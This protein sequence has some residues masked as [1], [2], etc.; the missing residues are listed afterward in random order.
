VRHQDAY[1]QYGGGGA[2]K[3]MYNTP[4]PFSRATSPSL[5]VLYAS[6]YSRVLQ[7]T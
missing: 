7:K 1:P 3:T 6:I 5:I 2:V 4:A